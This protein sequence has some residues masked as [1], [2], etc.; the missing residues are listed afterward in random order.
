MRWKREEND[1]ESRGQQNWKEKG[2]ER[3]SNVEKRKTAT[4]KEERRK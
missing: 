2:E 4:G 1:M 3:R